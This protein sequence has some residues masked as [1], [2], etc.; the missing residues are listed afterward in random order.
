MVFPFTLL[1]EFLKFALGKN[2]QNKIHGHTQQGRRSDVRA[3][4][5]KGI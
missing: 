2:W 3:R 1:A 5:S 4:G